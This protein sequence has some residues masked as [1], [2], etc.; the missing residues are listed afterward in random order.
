[1]QSHV[2]HLITP[3]HSQAAV[4]L[5]TGQ[6][7]V[8]TLQSI[9]FHVADFRLHDPFGFGV[10][11]GTCNG[12]QTEVTAQGEK[13]RMQTSL[14]SRTVHDGSAQVIEDEAQRTATKKRQ[15]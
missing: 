8:T 6:L 10:P 4:V 14:P 15:S 12:L 7:L 5:P 1:M 9:P 3:V 11:P 2:G 13:F